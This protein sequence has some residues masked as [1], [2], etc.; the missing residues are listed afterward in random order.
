[1]M[2]AYWSLVIGLDH[3]TGPLDWS[4]AGPLDMTTGHV[5]ARADWIWSSGQRQPRKGLGPLDR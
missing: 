1:M 3:W 2:R 4:R 5:L